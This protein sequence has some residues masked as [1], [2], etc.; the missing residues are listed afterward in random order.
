MFVY[1]SPG[2]GD[3]PTI[4]PPSLENN[5]FHTGSGGAGGAGGSGGAGGLGGR[6]AEGGFSYPN[7]AFCTE[8]GGAGGN[9]GQGG[10][11]AGG[12]GG[13]GGNSYG[14]FLYRNGNNVPSAR[15]DAWAHPDSGNGFIEDG[16]GGPGGP[17]GT[18]TGAAGAHGG[19]GID[20]SV[21][22]IEIQ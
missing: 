10:A 9:G 5:R 21:I 16:A 11:G 8:P 2:G 6:G 4:Q 12:G 18:S 20:G 13:C 14:I 17:G 7:Q 3:P 15:T 1:F 19:D 22:P